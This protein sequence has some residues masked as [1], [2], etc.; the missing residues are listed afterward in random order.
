MSSFVCK[1]PLLYTSKVAS[2]PRQTIPVYSCEQHAYIL[3]KLRSASFL[4]FMSLKY[5]FIIRSFKYSLPHRDRKS[6]RLK[7][8][9]TFNISLEGPFFMSTFSIF[10]CMITAD[11]LSFFSACVDS[12]LNSLA[13]APLSSV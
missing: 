9:R 8:N 3:G 2:C 13:A 5:S 1:S 6:H 10:S 7:S 12:T 11:L 4:S